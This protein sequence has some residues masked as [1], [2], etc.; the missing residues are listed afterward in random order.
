[1]FPM[2]TFALAKESTGSCEGEECGPQQSNRIRTIRDR[3]S[4][5]NDCL[6]AVTIIERLN[7]KADIEVA[8]VDRREDL[9]DGRTS[10]QVV[11]NPQ[12]FARAD[13][14]RNTP[15][16]R[17]FNAEQL[18]EAAVSER[19]GTAVFKRHAGRREES[20]GRGCSQEAGARTAKTDGSDDTGISRRER[21]VESDGT[22]NAGDDIHGN[23]VCRIIGSRGPGNIGERDRVS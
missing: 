22:A 21:K 13:T 7:V 16:G 3:G 12:G 10:G 4:S 15:L 6:L 19:R 5:A 17:P 1:M 18:I 23:L 9:S 8:G 20:G 2:N 11:L 14:V